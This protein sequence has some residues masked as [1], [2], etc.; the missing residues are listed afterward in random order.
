MFPTTWGCSKMSTHDLHI[1]EGV[2]SKDCEACRKFVAKYQLQRKWANGIQKVR[3]R[4]QSF[5]ACDHCIMDKNYDAKI[6]RTM[7]QVHKSEFEEPSYW[8]TEW[9]TLCDICLE[10]MGFPQERLEKAPEVV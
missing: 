4:E 7:Y 5:A 9:V 10:E 2:F 6:P 3:A 1:R 8:Q